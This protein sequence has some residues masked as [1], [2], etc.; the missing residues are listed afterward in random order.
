MMILILYLLNFTLFS[1]DPYPYC[2]NKI[3]KEKKGRKKEKKT[4]HYVTKLNN[5]LM[6]LKTKTEGFQ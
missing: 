5:I 6:K 2:N 1:S 3:P 4:K